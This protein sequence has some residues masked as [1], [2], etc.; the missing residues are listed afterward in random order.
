MHVVHERKEGGQRWSMTL[1]GE[2]A[3]GASNKTVIGSNGWTGDADVRM[4]HGL[5]A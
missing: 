1:D 3:N 5:I 4:G 2:T